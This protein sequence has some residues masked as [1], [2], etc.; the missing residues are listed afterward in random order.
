[1]SAL[2]RWFQSRGVAVYGYDRTRSKL[3]D[4]LV[5]EGIK[6]TYDDDPAT[7]P[8]DMDLVVWTP[9]I[10]VDN[11]LRAAIEQSGVK[12]IKRAEVLGLISEAYRTF[13]AA[14][15]H[16]KT[17][18]TA[19]LAHL[20]SEVFGGV[21]AFVGGVMANTGT[22]LI[23]QDNARLCV[24]EADEFD[25]SFLHLHPKVA[26]ITSTDADHLDIYGDEA[27]FAEGFNL[28]AGQVSDRLLVRYG[29]ELS[30]SVGV[31]QYTYGVDC[32]AADF[33]GTNLRVESGTMVFDLITPT[34]E[35]L[36][37]RLAMPGIHN[38]ENA[39]ASLAVMLLEG[40]K[41]DEL[42]DALSTFRGVKRRFERIVEG[43]VNYIDDYAH[44]PTELKAAISS[45]RMLFPDQEIMGVFQP[46]LFSRTRDFM[47]EFAAELSRL[48]RVRLLE[49]YPAR[50]LP[51]EGVT[52]AALLK[53][54]D[55]TDKR[56]VSNDELLVELSDRR[57]QV[58]MTLGA[59]DIDRLVKP[60]QEVLTR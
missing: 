43:D 32:R 50:E 52:S 54:I 15:T 53:E 20:S 23:C 58:I 4:T 25:R 11:R 7:L 45:A 46:H 31:E 39:V 49:I 30:A 9:A 2:A 6:I 42:R 57:P 44:H 3:T 59:G 12:M 26:V 34:A 33:N 13:A 40:A 60:I 38:V 8:S 47:T 1:M 48:D 10:P 22:N 18:T 28:F 35:I 29:V 14:G 27:S 51:I 17:T 41:R 36:G 16:G 5:A 21:Q 55:G 56:L 19:M 24:V 37:F